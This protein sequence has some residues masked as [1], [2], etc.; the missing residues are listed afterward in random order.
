[1]PMTT[2]KLLGFTK[3]V[4]TQEVSIYAPLFFLVSMETM[5]RN[6]FELTILFSCPYFPPILQLDQL[7]FLEK[8]GQTHLEHFWVISIAS[9]Q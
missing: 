5:F 2:A 8:W 1:M 4:A 7:C 9:N 6:I 3:M